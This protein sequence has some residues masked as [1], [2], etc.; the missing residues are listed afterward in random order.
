MNRWSRSR[1]VPPASARLSEILGRLGVRV[2]QGS[3]DTDGLLARLDAAV[4]AL[5]VHRAAADHL[6]QIYRAAIESAPIALVLIDDSGEEVARSQLASTLT[7]GGATAA[8]PERALRLLVAKAATADDAQHDVVEVFGPPRRSLSMTAVPLPIGDGVAARPVLAV[9]EDTTE[10][11][12]AELARRDF[13][14]NL[15]HELRT[16]VGAL[17]LLAE[18]IAGEGDP[19]TIRRLAGRL[20]V[21]ATRL[22]STLQD[23]LALSRLEAEGSGERQSVDLSDLVR[24]CV[25][26]LRPNAES[27]GISL[28]DDAVVSGL[29]VIGNR[30]LLMTAIDNL[31]D[32]AVK[33]SDKQEPVR[34]SVGAADDGWAEISVVDSGVGIPVRERQRIF[35]RFYR[36]DRARSRDTG[37]SGLGLAIV[38]HVAVSHDGS[39]DVDSLEGVGSTFTLRLPLVAHGSESEHD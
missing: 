2:T 14:T 22:S 24:F 8:V 15:S 39:V 31:L 37:G 32:N 17:A 26:R 30:S 18:T 35:E 29:A 33:Y 6:M 1:A 5:D 12:R 13:V 21:E 7:S 3:A 16:P 23:V 27:M 19:G 20:E 9:I 28:I 4:R 34:V 10:W 11:R 25:A 38:R 36:V